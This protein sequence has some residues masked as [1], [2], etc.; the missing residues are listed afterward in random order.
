[1][2]RADRNV[3]DARATLSTQAGEVQLYRLDALERAG[4]AR[5]AELPYTIRLLLENVLRNLGEAGDLEGHI[6]AL[7]HGASNGEPAR[8]VPLKPARVLLEDSNG[9][10]VLVDLAAMRSAVAR[11]GGNPRRVD[12]QIPVDLVV[13]HSLQVDHWGCLEAAALNGRLEFQRNRERYG[14]LR[15]CQGAFSGLRVV[16]P[17]T[18][19]GHQ[20]NLE[21]LAKS[22]LRHSFDGRWVAAPDSLVGTG[23]RAATTSALGVLGLA[24]SGMEAAAAMLGHTLYLPVPQVI[25]CRLTG[26][27]PE[28]VTAIELALRMAQML[29]A[30]R[31]VGKF[32]EFLGEGLLHLDVPARAAVANLAPEYGAALGFFPVD[33][34]T[35]DYLR[36]TGRAPEEIDLVERYCK[37]QLLFR[38]ADSLEPRYAQ[39]VELDLAT[40]E[41]GLA[42]YDQVEL[43]PLSAVPSRWRGE[44]A[45]RLAGAGGGRW[46]GVQ[47]EVAAG[48]SVTAP[49]PLRLTADGSARQVEVELDGT[50]VRL[51]DGSVVVAGITGCMS[52]TNP[53][54]MLAAGLLAKKAVERGLTAKPWV[55]TFLALGSP[56]VSE[57]LQ[58]SGLTAYLEKLGFHT[59]GY[60]CTACAGDSGPLAQ[61][62]LTVVKQAGLIVASVLSGRR[63]PEGGVHPAVKADCLAS[64]ALVVAYAIAGRIDIDMSRDP[65]GQ[66]ATGQPVYLKDIWPADAEVGALCEEFVTPELFRSRYAG[67]LSGPAEWQRLRAHPDE[68]YEWDEGS[69]FIQEPPYFAELPSQPPPIAP[70]HAARC[71]AVLG[72]DVTT[73]QISP[74]G[75]IDPN[76]PAGKYLQEQGVEPG[77]FGGY[78]SRRGNYQVMTR[79][80]FANPRIR[81]LLAPGTE[82]GLTVHLPSGNQMSI[83][84]AASKYKAAGTP[85]I[86]LA[87]RD[88]GK[89]EP[90]DWAA[91]GTALLGVRAVLAASFGPAHRRDLVAMGVLPLQFRQGQTYESLGLSGRGFYE[92][93]GLSDDLRPLQELTVIATDPE[94]ETRIEFSVICRIDTEV[95]LEYYR[96][97]GVLPMLLRGLLR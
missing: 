26:R 73:N 4:L 20:I 37:E 33:Y 63:S 49:G 84:D 1:M 48:A 29:R 69:T 38:G 77:E 87:G 25:A 7:V 41:A 5:I 54:L 81:N 66:D 56:A 42:V 59:V 76:S 71:L 85:L 22:V 95:E 74:T 19:I 30:I 8:Q 86:V 96:C 94:A 14:F 88:Y 65:L 13:D 89:G 78:A 16:P 92:F 82:G 68:V 24:V 61:R 32:V 62:I 93:P 40:L 11:M 51:T 3:L 12:P 79:G 28:G 44:L 31:P 45:A 97:G 91:K 90:C 83:F 50:R 53:G 6:R 55:K 36:L 46:L 2:G 52:T 21:H 15:W 47:G 58:R 35:L 67:L 43:V 17:A 72:D 23:S 39:V 27:L 57:Y 70:I 80:T 75:P 10:P 9:I 60:G 64:P 18:G 34:R